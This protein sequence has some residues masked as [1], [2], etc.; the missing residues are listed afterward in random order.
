MLCVSA[1]SS[2]RQEFQRVSPAA[3]W[4][5]TMVPARP[6]NPGT[7]QTTCK[8]DFC[9]KIGPLR[10]F[11]AMQYFGRFRSEADIEPDL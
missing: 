8:T 7:P 10:H 6:K 9:N 2:W 4:R 11:T 1:F 3:V 5:K